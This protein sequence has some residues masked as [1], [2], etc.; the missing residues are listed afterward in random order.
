[1]NRDNSKLA[2]NR[3]EQY[4]LLYCLLPLSCFRRREQDYDNALKYT[5]ACVQHNKNMV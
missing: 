3:I 1:M 2:N 5:H 4:T